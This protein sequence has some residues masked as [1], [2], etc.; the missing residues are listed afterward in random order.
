[1]NKGFTPSQLIN[2]DLDRIKNYKELLDFYHGRHWE[3]Y[4]RRGEKRLT[5]N[6]TKVVI[7]K[8]TSYLMSGTNFTVESIE[9]SDEARA[10]A[11]RAEQALHR[12][13][14]ENN[15]EQ[16]DF[17][18]E[19][20]CAILGDA[21]FKV[22]WDTE[23]KGVR[24]T[25]PDIQGIY[26]WWLGDDPSRVWRVASKYNLSSEEA[27]IL[28]KVKPKSKT[29]DVVELWTAQE[30]ELWL[31]ETLVEKKPNPYGFIPFIIHPN[32]RGDAVLRKLLS[33]V[34]DAVFIEGNKAY[35]VNPQSSDSS[36]Y[37]YGSSHPLLEGKYQRK[38]WG[39]NRVQVEGYDPT[40]DEL[41]V[42][43][44]FS[45]AEITKL[46]DRLSQVEDR[47]IDTVAEAEQR[48]E[49]YLRQAEIESA[50]SAIRIPPNCGQ[51]LYDVIDIT[52]SRAGLS[53]EKKR[54]IGLTLVYHHHRGEYEQRLLLGAV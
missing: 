3:G 44:S 48:G 52:D 9:D 14:E 5:F 28:Y 12:V 7:D 47:N 19:I 51:Q 4:P 41:I 33:F 26:A 13:Y 45:W 46:Y 22:I 23:R 6:Y 36:A 24:I 42:V 53:E 43:D 35:I 38:G 21:C 17:E 11:Q 49:A 27:E 32:N 8:I 37:S 54:L 31:D 1:M 40:G 16:L 25:T 10:R 15:L 2:R 39:L 20:D 30:F 34:P 50:T 18:T 29:A